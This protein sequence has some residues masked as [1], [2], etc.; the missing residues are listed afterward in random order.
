VNS[1]FVYILKCSD[2]SYYT[3]STNNLIKRLDEH[4][5]GK[6]KGY[7]NTRLP[8]KLVLSQEFS[9]VKEAISAERKIKGWS[10]KKK[11]ALIK[12]DFELLHKFSECNNESHFRNKDK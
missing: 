10:R 5:S 3:G 12:G 1:Y 2:S 4:N 8:V 6:Y 9:D 11:D 7:T